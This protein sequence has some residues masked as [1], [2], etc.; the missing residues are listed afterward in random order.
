[1]F[2]FC[3]KR[4]ET[5]LLVVLPILLFV[6]LVWSCAKNTYADISSVS[7][8]VVVT[9]CSDG[10][11]NDNDSLIDYGNDTGCTSLSDDNETDIYACSDGIDN[12]S[13][14]QIDYPLDIGC[15]SASDN[16]EHNQGPPS[17]DNSGSGG[18]GGGGGGG[19]S[20][21]TETSDSPAGGSQVTMKGK[22]Y[23]N[24]KITIMKGAQV[25]DTFSSLNDGKFSFV[26]NDV[27]PGIQLFSIFAED[28]AGN[29]S[30]LFTFPISVAPSLE[31]II[32]NIFISPTITLDKTEVK[33]GDPVNIS[34]RA[35][36]FSSVQAELHSDTP[37]YAII[38]ANED[39]LYSY[40]FDTSLL[41][42]GNHT[43]KTYAHINNSSGMKE[44][45][46]SSRSLSFTVGDN[47]IFLSNKLIAD[48]N[49]DKKINLVDF[50]IAS[51]WYKL[52]NPPKHIDLNNDGAVDLIDLSIMAYNWTG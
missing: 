50:S 4:K 31:T 1:M 33:K 2:L 24:A 19:G 13:D 12:D 15:T 36:P 44:Q 32:D 17:G 5:R 6:V 10:I 27:S 48:V 35:F 3:G 23:K 7:V 51:Y 34:G 18:G 20:D 49:D 40:S 21:S 25:L 37:N 42:L 52:P 46:V 8:S 9:Q 29:R 26:I 16:N 22:V 28:S 38:T 30:S 39:G 47:N 45:S 43:I 11:D 14:G 41:E